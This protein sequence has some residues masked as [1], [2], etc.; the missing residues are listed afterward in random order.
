[1][2]PMG[3]LT[4]T[5][6]CCEGVGFPFGRCKGSWIC[7]GDHPALPFCVVDFEHATFSCFNWKREVISQVPIND[8]AMCCLFSVLAR[9]HVRVEHSNCGGAVEII[10]NR[11]VQP[12]CSRKVQQLTH[13]GALP[14]PPVER[15]CTLTAW[16]RTAPW[17]ASASSRCR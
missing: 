17:I 3:R 1:M 7:L 10:N 16:G 9:G 11:T 4:E 6:C 12:V 5:L 13:S 15:P 14:F 2:A 8:A